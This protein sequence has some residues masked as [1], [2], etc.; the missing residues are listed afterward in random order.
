MVCVV[1]QL[2]E[3]CYS[4]YYS[5]NKDKVDNRYR[6][7]T[8]LIDATI[9]EYLD[10]CADALL[11][12]DPGSRLSILNR[13]YEEIIRSAGRRLMFTPGWAG[14]TIHG[15]YDA[16][17]MISSLK[18]EG[19]DGNGK[20][21]ISSR[22]HSN[23]ETIIEL[24]SPVSVN[25]YRAV[26]KLLEMSSSEFSILSD[27]NKIYGFGNLTGNYD[28]NKENL[29]SINFKGYYSWE[30]E[31]DNHKMMFVKN[32]KPK[33]SKTVIEKSKFKNSVKRILNNANE[34]D[35]WEIV[36]EATKQKHGTMI[37]ISNGAKDEAKRLKN[38]STKIK[39]IQITNKIVNMLTSID[40]AVLID[41]KGVCH[42][43]GVILDGMASEKGTSARGA[44]Y[45]S[46]IRYIETSNYPTLAVVISEDS[47]VNLIP[48][49]M[50][51]ISK[52]RIIEKIDI[53]E[54]L[55]NEE[56]NISVKK[57]NHTMDW[58]TNYSFYLDK[59]MCEKIN[60]LKKE[61]QPKLDTDMKILYPDL[62]PNEEMNETYFIEND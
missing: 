38:Q 29:F 51:Q 57:F 16:C 42:A 50:P 32:G 52:S 46:A 61:I 53:L 26:R 15:L 58:L 7:S 24:E 3:K 21:L 33:L 12:P 4:N 37:V 8:S 22:G 49:L 10:G 55:Q 47:T 31:H 54:R 2:N 48:D 39:P 36:I 28:Q 13:E 43:I 40:G 27:A 20:M 44:R 35:L 45:N 9:K 6:I 25:N 59:D 1:L 62:T 30:L 56:D 17:N 11:K 41:P 60:T 5:L 34:E 23:I 18:Y 19:I 14:N